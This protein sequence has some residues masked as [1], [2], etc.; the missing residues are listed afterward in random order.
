MHKKVLP[1]VL[2]LG[3]PAPAAWTLD[4][5]TH[6]G[7]ADLSA[8]EAALAGH[9]TAQLDF[10]RA[11]LAT[12]LSAAGTDDPQIAAFVDSIDLARFRGFDLDPGRVEEVR[13]QLADTAETLRAYGWG[14]LANVHDGEDVAYVLM[15]SD[16]QNVAGLVAMFC[17]DD[18]G[19]FV[20]VMGEIDAAQAMAAVLQ[21]FQSLRRLV[22]SA[23]AEAGSP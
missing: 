20:H 13:A 1:L 14:T 7:Y 11:T 15:K 17:G 5:E 19:G 3:L 16:G 10:D 22:S 12:L 9:L 8:L 2:L 6:P 4:L 21:H 23:K 18:E